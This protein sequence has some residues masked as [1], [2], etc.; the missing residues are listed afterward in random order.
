MF[1]GAA[2]HGVLEGESATKRPDSAAVPFRGEHQA[3]IETPR[4]A[5]MTFAAFDFAG[6]GVDDL[7][8]VLQGWTLAGAQMTAGHRLGEDPGSGRESL[9]DSGEAADLGASNLTLSFGLGPD[10]FAKGRMEGMDLPARRPD[11]LVDVPAFPGD[12]LDPSRSGGDLCVHACA[13]DPQVAFH[14][15]RDL[16]SLGRGTTIIKWIQ[17]AFRGGGPGSPA[18]GRNLLG[19]RDG[20][21]NLA[22]SDPMAMTQSVWVGASDQP[23][24]MRGGTY[25]VVR[26]I[27]MRIEHWD[28]VSLEEQEQTFG[29]RKASGAPLGGEVES[30]AVDP[31]KLPPDCHVIQA[32]PRTG[33]SEAE[34]IL[35]RS[36]SFSDGI[37]A[38]F[39]ELDAGLL[40][41]SQDVV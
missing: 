41:K 31:A 36:Y 27:R 32:N 1:L 20:S 7:R 24:W 13:D 38:R 26:R 29:R 40:V 2:G 3:G 23:D 25:M 39:G 37:D 8:A 19:F 34:R 15:V 18:R 16:A 22:V 12:Q 9:L 35:R 33:G 17:Q 10:L 21:N 5:Y 11:A 28:S 30:D 4:Q 14:A 6:R